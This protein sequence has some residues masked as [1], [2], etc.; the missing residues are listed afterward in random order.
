MGR[1]RK[2]MNCR[3]LCTA[4]ARE[5]KLLTFLKSVLQLSCGRTNLSLFISHPFSLG[6]Y[7]ATFSTALAISTVSS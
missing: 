5:D 4:R 1:L 3:S 2:R 7:S 6:K